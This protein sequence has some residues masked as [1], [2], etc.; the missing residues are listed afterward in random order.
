MNCRVSI[1]ADLP[2]S[3]LTLDGE[4]PAHQL[5][6]LVAQLAQSEPPI[7]GEVPAK[8]PA[9]KATTPPCPR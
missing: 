2:T 6:A 9:N 1:T 7:I 3:T 4:L 8:V 5:V